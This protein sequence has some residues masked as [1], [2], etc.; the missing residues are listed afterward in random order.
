MGEK[1]RFNPGWIERGPAGVT[2]GGSPHFEEGGGFPGSRG[3]LQVVAEPYCLGILALI[4]CEA[5][6]QQLPGNP[7]RL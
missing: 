2:E 1:G 4:G 3:G 7:D 5:S 6:A